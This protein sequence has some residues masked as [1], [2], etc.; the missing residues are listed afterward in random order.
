METG[1]PLEAFRPLQN[2]M[3]WFWGTRQPRGK[4]GRAGD[5][6][7]QSKKL[8]LK[9]KKKTWMDRKNREE[10]GTL[11]AK[12]STESRWEK[13]RSGTPGGRKRNLEL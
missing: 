7:D 12:G 1:L 10:A 5:I 6:P 11:S 9:S 3:Q 2:K 8:P 4:S 13:S